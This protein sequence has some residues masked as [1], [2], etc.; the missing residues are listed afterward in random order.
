MNRAHDKVGLHSAK[1]KT[2]AKI[3]FYWSLNLGDSEEAIVDYWGTE[4]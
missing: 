4:L 3:S 1:D 2:M